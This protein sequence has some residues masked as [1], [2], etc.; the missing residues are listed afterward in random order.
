[1]TTLNTQANISFSCSTLLCAC[2]WILQLL[3]DMLLFQLIGLTCLF[4]NKKNLILFGTLNNIYFLNFAEIYTSTYHVWNCSIEWYILSFSVPLLVQLLSM[5][6]QVRLFEFNW[7]SWYFSSEQET[8]LFFLGTLKKYILF[9]VLTYF[10]FITH[11]E[12]LA[13]C[14]TFSSALCI[15]GSLD[16]LLF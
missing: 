12:S 14:T 4:T 16:V 6:L 9:L 5:H 1:M 13:P 2:K 11:P 8:W 10:Q 7:L 15:Y 3:V